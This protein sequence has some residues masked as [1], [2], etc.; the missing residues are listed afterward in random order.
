MTTTGLDVAEQRQLAASLF[1]RVWQLLDLE[2]RTEVESAEM[3][4]GAHAS[5]YHWIQVGEPVN[6]ARGEWQCSRVYAVLGRG[7]PAMWH[8][9]QVLE[10][11]QAHDIKDFDLA[12]AYEALAR[13]AAINGDAAASRQWLAQ[14]VAA[15]DQIAEDDDRDL[16]RSDLATI[17]VTVEPPS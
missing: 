5:T 4:H 15:C 8:A 2:R 7:E 13:S 12:F 9:Q 11:C 1:N 14:A 17:P 16:V 3:L 6:R 10:I